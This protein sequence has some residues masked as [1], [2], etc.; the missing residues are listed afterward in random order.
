[1]AAKELVPEVRK[2]NGSEALAM[3]TPNPFTLFQQALERGLTLEQLQTFQLMCERHEAREARMAF[4]EAMACFKAE[5]IIISRDKTNKQYDSKYVSLGNLINTVTPYLSKHGLS[6]RWELDQSAGIKVTC[7]ITHRLNHS[8]S[9]AMTV[10]PD[11]SGQ[12]NPIQQIKSAIT[13]AKVCTFESA[14]GLA[15]SDGNV[16]DDGNGAG[17]RLD[18][19]SERLEFIANCNDLTELQKVYVA[20]YKAAK[21]LNDQIAM[22]RLTAAKDARKRELQ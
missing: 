21:T 20:A 1:M 14:C 7:V 13:Y 16:D 22:K 17:P 15:S 10:P 19:L 6:A 12:K 9:V 18:D 11:T 3:V 5:T 8:E 2:P 4:V